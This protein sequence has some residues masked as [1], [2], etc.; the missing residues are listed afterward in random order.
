[1]KILGCFKVVPDLEQISENDWTV[2]ERLEIDTGYVKPV[3]NCFD[4]SALE[5]MLKLSDFSEGFDVVYK[6]SALTVGNSRHDSFLKI[7]YAL[8]YEEAVRITAEEALVFSPE[9]I[10]AA[11]S[12]YIEKYERQDV[13]VMGQQSSDGS[14]MQTPYLLAECLGWPCISQVTGIT[15]ID[16]KS[17]KVTSQVPGGSLIQVVKV[18]CVLA[19]GNAADSYL[20]VPTLKDKIKLGKKPIRC[21]TLDDV[22]ASEV[23]SKVALFGLTA[24]DKK[25][26]TIIIEGDSPKEKAEVLF[27][28][29]LKERMGKL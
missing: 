13:V 9:L 8:K 18:P 14:N 3:W 11:V 15:P 26:D 5:M 7:L 27:N 16:E 22:G 23:E 1:M 29:Y 21:L 4:E 24:T 28:N 17:L 6:L 12:G 19:V 20:R 25:R 2:N 10:A